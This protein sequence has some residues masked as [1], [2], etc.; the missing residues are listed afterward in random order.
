[1]PCAENVPVIFTEE[2]DFHFSA[3]PLAFR[4]FATI[5]STVWAPLT[6]AR[7]SATIR[8]AAIENGRRMDASSECAAVRPGDRET[9][10]QEIEKNQENSRSPELLNSC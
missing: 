7:A 5:S 2:I 6:V 1:M 3:P 10:Q 4:F 9:I 8:H